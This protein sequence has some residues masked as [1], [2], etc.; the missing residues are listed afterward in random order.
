MYCRHLSNEDIS[1]FINNCQNLNFALI[2]NDVDRRTLSSSNPD[3][4]TGGFR[5][6]DLTKAPFNLA[7]TV[8]L[9]YVSDRAT[10]QVLLIDDSSS[11]DVEKNGS[12]TSQ[13]IFSAYSLNISLKLVSTVTNGKKRKPLSI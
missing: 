12:D 13:L 7:G 8:A 5:Q 1:S 3:I 11:F 2:T 10:K 9:I 6:L 4:H